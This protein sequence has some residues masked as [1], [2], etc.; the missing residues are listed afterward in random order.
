MSWHPRLT[1]WCFSNEET[2]TIPVTAA[3]VWVKTSYLKL[4][5][6]DRG[7]LVDIIVYITP[8]NGDICDRMAEIETGSVFM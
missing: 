2:V 7:Y 1:I 8:V 5:Y 4:K 6:N 3:D